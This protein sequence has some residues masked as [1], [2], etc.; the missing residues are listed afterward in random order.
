MDMD[1]AARHRAI[2][3]RHHRFDRRLFVAVTTTRVYRRPFCPAPMPGPELCRFVITVAAAQEAGFRPCLRCR[4]ETTPDLAFWRGTSN[5]VSRAMG[6]IEARVGGVFKPAVRTICSQEISVPAA[7]K[8]VGTLVASCGETITC[9]TA[10]EP[11]LTHVFPGPQH[12]RGA[13]VP[14]SYT[15]SNGDPGAS[16][17]RCH[18]EHPEPRISRATEKVLHDQQIA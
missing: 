4:G 5:T 16:T 7:R 6:M 10:I 18:R 3:T 17:P 8:L 1:A 13:D 15:P 14:A 9:P 2:E 11:G 12:L